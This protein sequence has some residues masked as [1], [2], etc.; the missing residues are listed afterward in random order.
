MAQYIVKKGDNL[1][2]IAKKN[3]IK[4]NEILKLNKLDD[5]N[6]IQIGQKINLPVKVES[7]NTISLKNNTTKPYKEFLEDQLKVKTPEN[8]WKKI[9]PSIQ[10]KT[11]AEFDKKK[12]T[13]TKQVINKPIT[14]PITKEEE[15]SF[16]SQIKNKIS[17]T[18][19]DIKTAVDQQTSKKTVAKPKVKIDDSFID[20]GYK[21]LGTY[22]DESFKAG[23]K[24]SL[25]SAMNVFDNDKGFDYIVSPKVKEGKKT[26]NNVKGVAH[27][28]MDSDITPNQKYTDSYLEKGN[29][30]VKS[31]QA[32]KFTPY[33]GKNPDDY[34]MYYK[35]ID[36]SK[37]N[38]KYGQLKDKDKY[39]G[40][41]QIKVRSIPFGELDFN[42]KKSAGFAK[43]ASY[44]GTLDGKQTSIITDPE[45]NDVYGRFSGG[46]GIFHFKEPKTG[47]T[48]S[49]DVSG[50]V[51]TIK[52][53]GKELSKKYNVDPKQLQFLYHDMGSY[54]AKPKSHNGVISNEQWENYNSNNKGYSG[55][56]LMYP[57]EHGGKITAETIY[58]MN[59]QPK[60]ILTPNDIYAKDGAKVKPGVWNNFEPITYNRAND[61]PEA[62]RVSLSKIKNPIEG[63]IYI[64]DERPFHYK[65]G[66]FQEYYSPE[67]IK[68]ILKFRGE[69]EANKTSIPSEISN[70]ITNMLYNVD[71]P[72]REFIRS[73]K[74]GFT[75]DEYKD[76]GKIDL[77]N[78]V[79][80][81][82][83]FSLDEFKNIVPDYQYQ[84]YLN[85]GKEG[86]Y[87]NINKL[88][89]PVQIDTL[90]DG[91][92]TYRPYSYE[93]AETSYEDY[94]KL[95][96]NN[97]PIKATPITGFK[98]GGIVQA[99]VQKFTNGGMAAQQNYLD[100]NRIN[101][102]NM[103]KAGQTSSSGSAGGGM[104]GGSGMMGGG[105][106]DMFSGMFKAMKQ[107]IDNK[108]LEG[109]NKKQKEVNLHNATI[110]PY[111]N[112]Y[113]QF[114]DPNQMSQANN[115]IN[116]STPEM[117]WDNE[118]GDNTAT[119]SK[120]DTFTMQMG[121]PGTAGA[122]LDQI[123]DMA[124]QSSQQA[125]QAMNMMGGQSGGGQGGGMDMSQMMSMFKKK[126]GGYI[127]DGG[128][129]AS[130]M[131]FMNTNQSLKGQLPSYLSNAQVNTN[132]I[133]SQNYL[134]NVTPIQTKGTQSLT[135]NTT[136]RVSATPNK[137]MMGADGKQASG[138]TPKGNGLTSSIGGVFSKV[139]EGVQSLYD[140]VGAMTDA[141]S[142]AG[143]W[144]QGGA[145]AGQIAG[146]Y[147]EGL[148]NIPVYGEIIAA[149]IDSVARFTGGALNVR[150]RQ[151][152]NKMK[153][154]QDKVDE[155]KSRQA[156][157]VYD[158]NKKGQYMAKYGANP[159]M[160]EQRIIDDIYSDFDKHFKL[161]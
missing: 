13:P 53:V 130:Y 10:G 23:K 35:N 36:D 105:G 88:K 59:K 131:D 87:K 16:F 89:Y 110:N 37:M 114:D 127:A 75:Y 103:E 17:E 66:R 134:N 58:S 153:D 24:D 38:V 102:E 123:G 119:K 128:Y 8:N 107:S 28:L 159:K 7:T 99:W 104:M 115:Q 151:E 74:K 83:V 34:V 108:K 2:T 49:V 15:E 77:S 3:G 14:K 121:K 80:D 92:V 116:N 43:K 11:I 133:S 76:G 52:Q 95:S 106:M 60:V 6:L 146:K 93:S 84:G 9:T 160:M 79:G 70:P 61:Y 50:S 30:T 155:Y 101:N 149:A 140:G 113:Q 139:D 135:N 142:G 63:K 62:E 19:S 78:T 56:A 137:S 86:L 136:Q 71:S 143:A 144:F 96:Q 145:K 138:A 67:E 18:Y 150:D 48:I 26:F 129:N 54:S 81:R 120:F 55:A 148:K 118:E 1:S 122:M 132:Q 154:R 40:Y 12:D 97:Q 141:D 158:P 25:L 46:S 64:D 111:I 72:Y 4:L 156:P 39:K 161:K 100:L 126:Y 73:Q 47:K 33:L 44:I 45:S 117:T 32:G 157:L 112:S 90:P 51:N 27:F 69:Q 21:E 29:N 5:P 31:A 41:E 22:K 109:R 152:Y 20:Y 98:D 85:S 68:Q 124:Y 42:N 82:K 91:S 94:K 125:S 147:T 65:E 57:M